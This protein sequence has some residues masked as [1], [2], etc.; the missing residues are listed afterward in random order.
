MEGKIVSISIPSMISYFTIDK[1]EK[2]IRE[3]LQKVKDYQALV[4]DI[5]GNSCGTDVYWSMFLPSLIIKEDIS[6]ANYFL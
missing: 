2:L 6:I 5:R 3:Y 4:I 1:D